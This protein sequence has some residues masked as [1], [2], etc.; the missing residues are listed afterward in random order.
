MVTARRLRN[1]HEPSGLAINSA[2]TVYIAD[3]GNSVVRTYDSGVIVTVAGVG[4]V[5][6]FSGDGGPA[7]R[8]HMHLPVSVSVDAGNS[9]WV[10][11]AYNNALRRLVPV[12]CDANAEPT[13]ESAPAPAA[14][15]LRSLQ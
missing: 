1:L 10:A 5:A 9:A 2:G 4:G 15:T 12:A 3:A 7:L 6:G 8:A 14:R 11:D 13:P